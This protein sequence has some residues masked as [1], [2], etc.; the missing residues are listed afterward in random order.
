LRLNFELCVP[1]LLWLNAGFH[2][3]AE[4]LN[5]TQSTVRPKIA[6]NTICRCWL[7]SAMVLAQMR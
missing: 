4:P 7:G 1:L 3:A 6:A 5:L 2:R